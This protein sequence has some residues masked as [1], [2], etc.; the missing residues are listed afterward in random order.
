MKSNASPVSAITLEKLRIGLLQCVSK[1]LLDANVEFDTIGNLKR[2]VEIRISGHIWAQHVGTH[3]IIWTH[4]ANW[5]EAFKERWFPLW[6]KR[7]W[8]VQYEKRT[9]ALDVKATYP[10]LRL[11]V[12]NEEHRIVVIETPHVQRYCD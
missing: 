9:Y 1:L 4:P 3:T 5:K 8:H 12:P 10:N 11:S 2:M 7:R 6:A